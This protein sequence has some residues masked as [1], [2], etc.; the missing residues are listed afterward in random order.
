MNDD[1]L[2]QLS[3]TPIRKGRPPKVDALTSAE[4]ARRTREK[5]KADGLTEVKCHLTASSRSYLA[6][7]CSIHQCTIS[8][9]ISRMLESAMFHGLTVQ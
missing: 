4:R 5:R 2:S 9:A 6:A 3:L 8:D 1:F 7:I